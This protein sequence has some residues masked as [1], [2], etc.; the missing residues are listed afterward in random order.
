[1]KNVIFRELSI[2][3]HTERRARRIE[4]D[5]KVTILKGENQTG[6]SS[7]VKSIFAAFGATSAKVHVS[8]SGVNALVFLVFEINGTPY[9]ILKTGNKYALFTSDDRL[10]GVYT[11][12]TSGLGPKIADLFNFKLVM[13][14]RE[15][16]EVIPPPAYLFIPFYIDQ[17]SA[18]FK[19]WSSFKNLNQ[20]PKWR[21]DVTYYHTGIKPNEYYQ[22]LATARMLGGKRT[23]PLGQERLLMKFKERFGRDVLTNGVNLDPAVFERELAELIEKCKALKKTEEKY[24]EKLFALESERMRLDA[25]RRIVMHAQR[26]LDADYLLSTELPIDETICCP[27]CGQGYENSFA[28][29]FSIANDHQKC[30]TLLQDVMDASNGLEEEIQKHQ[31][32]LH[33]TLDEIKGIEEIMSQKKGDLTLVSLLQAMSSEYISTQINENLVEVR[34]ELSEI[35]AEIRSTA[36]QIKTYED[37]NRATSIIN[38]YKGRMGEYLSQLSVLNINEK[39]YRRIDCEAQETGSNLPRTS[40]A[41][42]FA[43]MSTIKKYGSSV[44]CPMVIDTPKQQD[45]DA[46]NYQRILRFIRDNNP[47]N[48]TIIALVDDFGIDFGGKVINMTE[49]YRALAE[50]EYDEVSEYLKSFEVAAMITT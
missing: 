50:E 42:Y 40:L 32:S 3:S 7:I 20:L 25:Q 24:R 26:E 45:P 47:S 6:K 49:K 29:R 9:K 13:L 39:A 18:W 37:R 43:V 8:W 30:V 28:N 15:Q 35:D 23:D 5:P 33:E 46:T 38:Y 10:I 19:T 17:E 21:K 31:K 14:D 48:Q 44:I 4:F 36:E 2:I 22:L 11:G 1:M 16:K 27:T 41:Y 12:V 34:T